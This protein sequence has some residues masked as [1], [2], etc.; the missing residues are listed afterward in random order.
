MKFFRLTQ[1]E[2][3]TLSALLLLGGLVATILY[4]LPS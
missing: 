4:W 2:R 1:A 3:Q